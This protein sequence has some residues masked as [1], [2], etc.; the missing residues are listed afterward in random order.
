MSSEYQQTVQWLYDQLPMFSVIGPGAY[1]PGLDTSRTLDTAFGHPHER[2]KSI[3]VGGTNGKGSVSHSLASV[4][5]A[6]GYKVGLYTSPH[7]VDF[8]ERIRVNGEMISEEAVVDFV[9]RYREYGLGCQPSF[10][11]L[12]T[13]MAFD[14]FAT[15]GVDYAVIEVGLGGR[16]D[17]TNII[18]PILSVITNISLDHV[19]LLGDTPAA[20]AREK[21]GIIK[22]GVPVV[23]GE[24]AGEVKEVFRQKAEEVGAPIVFADEHPLNWR[25]EDGRT[26]YSWVRTHGPCVP[27]SECIEVACD[28]IGSCQPKNAATVLAAL[29]FLPFVHREAIVEGMADVQARTGLMGRWMRM[30]D[31]PETICDTGHNSGAWQYLAPRLAAIA[32]L[33]TTRIVLGF[34]NDKDVD[35]IFSMLPKAAT[36]YFAAPDVKRARSAESLLALGEANG[37]NGR[38]FAS[39]KEA[40]DVARKESA[41]D[42]FVFVGGSNFVVAEALAI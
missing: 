31:N 16:L 4:L 7:L 11:E 25:E 22:P 13:I 38:A 30:A 1:K 35:A 27:T 18:T 33:R 8:R 10:F 24:S 39:V 36:Y 19:A 23:I 9:R 2:F 6:A 37:L 40:V 32:E 21:A 26:V 12:T 41:P 20:I 14:Y 17:T 42:D 28:L 29:D 34:A 15:Q 3:H 5:M